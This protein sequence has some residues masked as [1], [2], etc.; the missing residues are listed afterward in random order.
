MKKMF[1]KAELFQKAKKCQRVTRPQVINANHLQTILG[2]YSLDKF[3]PKTLTY[4]K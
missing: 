1:C 4:D 2:D 3:G